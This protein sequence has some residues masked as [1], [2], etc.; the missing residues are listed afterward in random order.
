MQL[1]QG[2]KNGNNF[3]I[4]FTQPSGVSDITFGAE[5]GSSISSNLADW[6]AIPDTGSGSAHTFS[7]SI[8]NNQRIFVRL[9]VTSS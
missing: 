4:S 6:T 5:W 1:Q 9:K 7:V 3:V 2:Q 8:G